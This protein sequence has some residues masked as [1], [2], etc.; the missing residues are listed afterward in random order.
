M[1][2]TNRPFFVLLAAAALLFAAGC[3]DSDGS[4][5]ANV[6][7]AELVGT[8]WKGSIGD[9]GATMTIAFTSTTACTVSVS[10]SSETCS[11]TTSGSTITITYS[12]VSTKA[13][14]YGSYIL[15]HSYAGSSSNGVTEITYKLYKE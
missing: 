14:Y 4:G 1:K 6:T 10:A 12:G 15:V 2:N 13:T 5:E 3:S 7:A 11:Y 8:S 9:S